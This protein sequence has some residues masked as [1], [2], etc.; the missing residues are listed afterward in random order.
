[1]LNA[2]LFHAVTNIFVIYTQI[3][4][5]KDFFF[6]FWLPVLREQV[7][8]ISLVEKLKLKPGSKI[9]NHKVPLEN[10]G[11]AQNTNM[12][13]KSKVARYEFDEPVK[14]KSVCIVEPC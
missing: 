5:F 7:C 6:N 4:V 10:K 1:M 13:R 2:K 14:S 12:T 8:C 9:K 3:C 11:N